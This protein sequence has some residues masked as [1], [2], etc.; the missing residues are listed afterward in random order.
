[1]S[2]YTKEQ[3]EAKIDA[4]VEFADIGEFIHQPLKTYS[5]GMKARLGFA[6]SINIEPEI[7]I[8]DEALS[9]GDVAFQ[10]KCYAKI[11]D[12][13]K[14]DAVTVLFVSHSENTIINLCS[15][16]LLLYNG[17]LLLDGKP[18]HVVTQY[19]KITKSSQINKQQIIHDFKNISQQKL[20]QNKDSSLFS[21]DL[22]SQSSVALEKNGG[23]IHSVAVLNN[24]N[25]KVNVLDYNQVY[26]FKYSVEFLED[27]KE[28]SFAMFIKTKDGIRLGGREK[29]PL[30]HHYRKGETVEINWHLKTILTNGYY[31]INCG[32]ISN[33]YERR[34]IHRIFDAYL[35]QV[36]GSQED[37]FTGHVNLNLEYLE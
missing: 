33:E 21:S 31:L 19:L 28:V 2:G 32:V 25:E 20:K 37:D 23:Y 16:A 22:L 3:M 11:E 26:K 36:R 30:R 10:R 7:L 4:I 17:E 1:I 24:N 18:N 14:N 6:F 15:R 34:V 35:F 5:S 12:M 27:A 29:K 9:V 13:C 8:I